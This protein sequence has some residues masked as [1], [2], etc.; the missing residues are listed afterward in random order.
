[1]IIAHRAG[2]PFGDDPI[3]G[4]ERALAAG[5]DALEVDVRRT[6]DGVMVV[7]HDPAVR[8]HVLART[9]YAELAR[10]LPPAEVPLELGSVVE[11]IADRAIVNLDLKEP[12]YEDEVLAAALAHSAPGR[13]LVASFL[14][15]VVARV[16]ALAPDV[17]TGLLVGRRDASEPVRGLVADLRPFWRIDACGADFLGPNGLFAGLGLAR[18]AAARGIPVMVWT[19]NRPFWLRRWIEDDRVFSVVTD[20]PWL[21]HRIRAQAQPSKG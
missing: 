12:G 19:I 9:T 4:V 13:L 7:C 6:R 14:D 20:A 1:L 11:R 15:S 17:R 10:V 3:G 18:A 16:K 5:A 21:A 2:V 8:D